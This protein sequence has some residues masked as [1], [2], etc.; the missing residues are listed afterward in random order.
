MIRAKAETAAPVQNLRVMGLSSDGAG[1]S[2]TS[3]FVP[4]ESFFIPSVAR[5]G[6]VT[7]LCPTSSRLLPR[8]PEYAH[9][10][11]HTQYENN[12]VVWSAMP[13]S[14]SAKH[15]VRHLLGV[16]LGGTKLSA[17]LATSEGHLVVERTVATDPS[18]ARAVVEQI[19]AL[20]RDMLGG[21][22]GGGGAAGRHGLTFCQL[23]S[24]GVLDPVSGAIRLAPNIPGLDGLDV[25]G[26]LRR[27]LACG[28]GVENDVA[29]AMY[30]EHCVGSARGSRNAAF[31]SLG[32]GIGCGI[33][34]DGRI[35]RGA[36]GGAGE[37]AYLP[38]GGDPASPEAKV[39][40]ALELTVGSSAIRA[41]YARRVGLEREISVREIFLRLVEG[42]AAAADVIDATARQVA[43][44]LYTLVVVLD[45]ECIILGGSIG[46]Q[47]MMRDRVK[48]HLDSVAHRPV[49]VRTTA[50]GSRAG[51]VGAVALSFAN[52]G[53]N[54]QLVRP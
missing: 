26:A 18:G 17:A 21:T 34:A 6:F 24:P 45:P 51:L 7:D 11:G 22:G 53:L 37:I 25:V 50:L 30:G 33:L 14:T 3:V 5:C 8:W 36:G 1:R 35:L 48:A 23:G 2:T 49:D 43:S 10:V 41:A 32:T 44:A 31:V 27:E 16:D 9:T 42:D 47:S 39:T 46:M 52:V 12:F 40:G 38:F 54:P 19:G 15:A 28:V 13:A 20:A 4:Y 29:V